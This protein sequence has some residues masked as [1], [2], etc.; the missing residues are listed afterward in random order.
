M[1]LQ[2]VYKWV[3]VINKQQNQRVKVDACIADEIQELNDQG[4]VTLGCCCGHGRAGEVIEWENA[5][6]KWKGYGAPPTALIREESV[7]AARWL[8][9]RPYPYYYADG[10]HENV[11][12][13]Q[14][15]TGCLTSYDIR[16]WHE[17]NDVPFEKDIGAIN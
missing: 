15:K 7:E 11:W 4:I 10:K 8:G 2:G 17:E 16:T 3:N 1:C 5:F 13:M 9:Y 6:G 12:Q 14:L